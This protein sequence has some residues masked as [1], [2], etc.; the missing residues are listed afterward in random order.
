MRHCQ[1]WA[2]KVGAVCGAD[3]G[4]VGRN[5]DLHNEAHCDGDERLLPRKTR[6]LDLDLAS[7][8]Y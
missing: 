8:Y 1:A 3:R 4:P 7:A 2:R 6:N 5:G